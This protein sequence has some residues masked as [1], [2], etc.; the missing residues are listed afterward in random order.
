MSL[1]TKVTTTGDIGEVT[2]DGVV[3][4]VVT[5]FV[6]LGALITRDG[7]CDEEIRNG[8]SC[9]ER[10]NNYMERQRSEACHTRGTGVGLGVLNSTVRSGDLDDEKSIEEEH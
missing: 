7:L 1:K 3:A 2:L 4:E 5:S 8:Q 6:Y 10:V 9:N